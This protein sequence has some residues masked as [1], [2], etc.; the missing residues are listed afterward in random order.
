MGNGSN[1]A[2]ISPPLP[3]GKIN[4]KVSSKPQETTPNIVQSQPPALGGINWWN[5]G[6][7]TVRC[8]NIIED[9]KDV[10]TFR[11]TGTS[12]TL[13]N[14]KPGQFVTL[15]LNIND[16]IIKRFYSISSTPSRPHTLEITV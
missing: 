2:V 3:T 8:L 6:K 1:G 12:P 13:F 10:K 4:N 14:Y 7:I 5:K 9:T 16:K 11:F 15:N